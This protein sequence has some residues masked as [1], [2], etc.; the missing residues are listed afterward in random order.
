ME[1]RHVGSVTIH[2]K[3][4]KEAVDLAIRIELKHFIARLLYV[5]YNPE[6]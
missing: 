1:S 4:R 3:D 5:H 6:V 2:F